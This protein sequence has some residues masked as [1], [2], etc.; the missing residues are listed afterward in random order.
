M[1]PLLAFVTVTVVSFPCTACT[2]TGVVG[3]IPEPGEGEMLT[4]ATG[5]GAGAPPAGPADGELDVEQAVSDRATA[6]IA[7][8][9]NLFVPK[10]RRAV[11]RARDCCPPRA[12]RQ[13]TTADH[14]RDAVTLLPAGQAR[15]Q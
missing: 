2:T 9:A 11:S 15:V 14:S 8:T 4:C 1:L 10:I 6:T 7:P 13:E 3:L 5:R 12:I